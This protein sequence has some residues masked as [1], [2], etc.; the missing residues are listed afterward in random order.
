M[1]QYSRSAGEALDSVREAF[2][3]VEAGREASRRE[4]VSASFAQ[5]MTALPLTGPP[6]RG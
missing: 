5:R 6:I 1:C 4:R 3:A 2:T